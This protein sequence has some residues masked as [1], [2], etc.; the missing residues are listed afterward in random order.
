MASPHP[1]SGIRTE[2]M[3]WLQPR[4]DVVV[5]TAGIVAAVP[6]DG[7]KS[8]GVAAGR[9][10]LGGA[11]LLAPQ[12]HR[13]LTPKFR[14]DRQGRASGAVILQGTHANDNTHYLGR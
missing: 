12:R 14:A 13:P 7:L 8:A 5:V 10:A 2:F 6:A 9:L 3:P 11:G 4:R 1:D